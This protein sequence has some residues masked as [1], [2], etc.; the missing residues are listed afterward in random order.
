[1]AVSGQWKIVLTV[2]QGPDPGKASKL[3]F[4]FRTI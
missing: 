4:Y 1:M 2:T 3:N